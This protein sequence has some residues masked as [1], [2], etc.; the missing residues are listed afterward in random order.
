MIRGAAAWPRDATM[1]TVPC[2][3]EGE[4]TTLPRHTCRSTGYRNS[5]H[6]PPLIFPPLPPSHPM[7]VIE[8]AQAVYC[9][10]PDL[11]EGCIKICAAADVS[12]IGLRLGSYL[13]AVA[14]FILV[15]VAPD[16]GGSE[17]LWIG[18]SISFAFIATVFVQMYQG[19]ITMH[20]TVVV[21]LLSNLPYLATLAGM[22]SLS[23]CEQG[24]WCCRMRMALTSIT[25][26]C[27]SRAGKQRNDHSTSG[28][29]YQGCIHS[30][31]L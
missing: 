4:L 3:Q 8:E 16:E 18:L 24:R 12:A 25:S 6:L 7:F 2:G 11:V 29:D 17:A 30:F 9:A 21:L 15:I 20:H 31:P 26:R 1:A 10:N 19:A 13:Q 23:S 5:F 14:F 27:R 22:N 28:I